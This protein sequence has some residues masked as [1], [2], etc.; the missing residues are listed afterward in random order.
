M[1]SPARSVAASFQATTATGSDT[2]SLQDKGV[3]G[4]NANPAGNLATTQ[5]DLG[6]LEDQP[7]GDEGEG[8]DEEDRAG[9]SH[10]NDE[11]DQDGDD[12]QA[13]QHDQVGALGR[14]DQP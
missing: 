3:P 13:E 7:P 10:P 2:T 12:Q 5:F 9:C 11:V 4:R 1:P 6:R 8:E 14:I